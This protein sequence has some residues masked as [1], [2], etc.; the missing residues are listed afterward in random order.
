MKWHYYVNMK[1]VYKMR[2]CIKVEKL[3]FNSQCSFILLIMVAVIIRDLVVK[4]F[5]FTFCE[6]VLIFL[7]CDMIHFKVFP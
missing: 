1:K 3:D 6:Q 2:P 7:L 4:Y 5:L